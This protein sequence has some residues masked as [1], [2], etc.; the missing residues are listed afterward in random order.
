MLESAH[1]EIEFPPLPLTYRLEAKRAMSY[2]V[3]AVHHL[4]QD[5]S[6]P[7]GFLRM[8]G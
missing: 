3:S 1:I 6:D 5:I 4:V 2:G 7:A 8:D